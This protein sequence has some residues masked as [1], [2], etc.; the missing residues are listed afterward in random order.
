MK[1]ILDE[2]YSLSKN[3]LN[4]VIISSLVIPIDHT[5]AI[6]ASLL[7][8]LIAEMGDTVDFEMITRILENARFWA[9]ILQSQIFAMRNDNT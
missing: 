2:V 9:N 5:D 4:E 3:G 1:N 7:N 8:D 6:A